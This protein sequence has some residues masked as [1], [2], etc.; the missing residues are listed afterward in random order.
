MFFQDYRIFRID[1]TLSTN[2]EEKNCFL[3]VSRW[4]KD[5]F[6]DE[7]RRG[8]LNPLYRGFPGYIHQKK[9]LGSALAKP[10]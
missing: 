10:V 4:V 5:I 9:G 1:L 7:G 8:K 3:S 6:K 2:K